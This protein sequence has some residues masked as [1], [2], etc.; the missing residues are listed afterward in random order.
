LRQQLSAP[1]P[2]IPLLAQRRSPQQPEPV[3]QAP[4]AFR[5]QLSAPSPAIPLLAQTTAPPLWLH[6]LVAVHWEPG[7]R[8]PPELLLVQTPPTQRRAPQQLG[9]LVQEPPSL[10]Q[11]LSSPSPAMPLLAQTKSPQ[12]PAPVVQAPP[13]L[14]QQ[15]SAPSLSIPLLAQTTAPPLWLH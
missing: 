9:P 12:H 4:P 6:W 8:P 13:P 3:V 10:W 14:R 15:L 2:V 5:Q 7:A 1:S 11:Q